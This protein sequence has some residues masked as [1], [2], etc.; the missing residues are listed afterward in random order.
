MD[1]M[2]YFKI[3]MIFLLHIF[4]WHLNCKIHQVLSFIFRFQRRTKPFTAVVLAHVHEIKK[5][6]SFFFIQLIRHV[7]PVCQNLS[8]SHP[9]PPP[10]P[11]KNHLLLFCLPSFMKS[12]K[13]TLFFHS[14]NSPRPP[15]LPKFKLFTTPPPQSIK[16]VLINNINID[17]VL[18]WSKILV[19][20]R[21][22]GTLCSSAK[23]R[24]IVFNS[25]R[26]LF[27]NLFTTLSYDTYYR[28][29]LIECTR[30]A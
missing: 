4:D 9:P 27:H 2:N 24:S 8:I 25:C 7:L 10:P 29:C 30:L 23:L 26:Q 6:H 28:C 13:V 17:A 20:R 16:T 19:L 18:I 21:Y 12:R 14:T 5:S 1:K 3:C 11:K 15:S 22:I